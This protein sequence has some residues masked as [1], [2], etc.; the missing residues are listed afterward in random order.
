[1]LLVMAA[2]TGTALVF[3]IAFIFFQEA[4]RR[5]VHGASTHPIPTTGL[6]AKDRWPT[7]IT[8]DPPCAE[9][10]QTLLVRRNSGNIPIM[11]CRA[12]DK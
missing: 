4:I 3:G 2:L 1:V 8:V 5:A 6:S 10:I 11:R 7:E 9:G 12:P